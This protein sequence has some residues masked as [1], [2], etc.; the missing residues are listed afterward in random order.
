MQIVTLNCNG[1]RSAARKGFFDWLET[2]SP[3]VVC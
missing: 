1:I 2:Q 3:D